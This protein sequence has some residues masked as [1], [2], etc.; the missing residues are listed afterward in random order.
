MRT[1][2]ADFSEPLIYKRRSFLTSAA[3][4]DIRETGMSL[5][6][7]GSLFVVC[8]VL[9]GLLFA[10]LNAI[11]SPSRHSRPLSGLIL[12]FLQ[13]CRRFATV[14]WDFYVVLLRQQTSE[15]EIRALQS[16]ASVVTGFPP[17]FSPS[18]P[19][20]RQSDPLPSGMT[21]FILIYSLYSAFV[22]TEMMPQIVLPFKVSANDSLTVR[23]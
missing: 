21:G 7:F 19:W 20:L 15:T 5:M 18:R 22:T 6:P 3:N 10:T 23:C 8:L 2:V 9:C 16:T 1:A 17:S 11:L 12:H 13:Y 14:T 4:I